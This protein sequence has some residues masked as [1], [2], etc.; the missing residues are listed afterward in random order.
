MSI[1]C[2]GSQKSLPKGATQWI[3]RNIGSTVIF[4]L[5]NKVKLPKDHHCHLKCTSTFPETL[6]ECPEG[7]ILVE[8]DVGGYGNVGN[9]PSVADQDLGACAALCTTRPGECCS[10]EWSPSLK[11][12]NLNQECAPTGNKFRDYLFCVKGAF[13][14]TNVLLMC[15]S[16]HVLRLDF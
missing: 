16:L 15:H 8:G 11:I 14:V 6:A 3:Q 2:F 1:L 13:D 10:F 5:V 4:L 12:C 9:E 7:Y